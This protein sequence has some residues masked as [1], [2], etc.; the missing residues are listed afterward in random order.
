MGPMTS[1]W[2]VP[3]ESRPVSPPAQDELQIAIRATGLCGSDLH[4]YFQGRN[5]SFI[6]RQPLVLGHE[7]IGEITQLGP[8][9]ASSSS[10]PFKVGDRVALEVGLPCQTCLFCRQ[11][12]YNICRS[13]RFRSSASVFPHL[14]GTLMDIT[15]HPARMCHP[16]PANVSDLQG[17]LLEPLAVCLHAINRS[18]PLT[19]EDVALAKSIAA[20]TTEATNQSDVFQTKCAPGETAALIFGAG[21]IGL[22]LASA[23]AA[24][25]P[26]TTIVIS[27]KN[28]ARLKIAETLP[29][30]N[31][32]TAPYQP[33]PPSMLSDPPKS[34]AEEIAEEQNRDAIALAST[35]RA[36]FNLPQGFARVFECTGSP[37]CARTAIH[38]STVGGAVI[39]IGMGGPSLPTIPLSQA[40][41]TEVDL[42]GVLRYDGK[43]YPKAIELMAS[44]AFEGVAEKIV[45]H[46]V[47]LGEEDGKRGFN[48]AGAGKDEDGN[49]VVK[50]VVVSKRET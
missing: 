39:Q 45:T 13:M 1:G 27:D 44:K 31:I 5:G 15:N 30:P 10:P 20:A 3:P 14:D 34:S 41:L 12:R 38:V 2:S 9:S 24:T 23:L 19:L 26:F 46:V 17:A 18:R 42:I 32:K 29:F 11:D 49:P 4:Y 6:V 21:S 43:C 48:L 36:V 16:L 40:A 37:L 25:Q 7:S 47:E 35:L 22:L 33:N 50:V 28:P 8:S